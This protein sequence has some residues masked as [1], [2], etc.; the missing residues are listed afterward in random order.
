MLKLVETCACQHTE[1]KIN[2]RH[3]YS[4]V[5]GNSYPYDIREPHLKWKYDK[6]KKMKNVKMLN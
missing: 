1:R 4:L 6:K 2:K 3:I 5:F